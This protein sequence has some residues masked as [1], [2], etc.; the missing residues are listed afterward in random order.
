M[1][2]AKIADFLENGVEQTPGDQHLKTKSEGHRH[3]IDWFMGDKVNGHCP[4]V[5]G[6]FI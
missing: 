4:S 5:D 1:E 6:P 3:K 2:R